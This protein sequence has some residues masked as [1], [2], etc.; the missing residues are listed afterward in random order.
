M[1]RFISFAR[2]LEFELVSLAKRVVSRLVEVQGLVSGAPYSCGIRGFR[3]RPAPTNGQRV[4][5]LAL[6]SFGS[7]WT[8]WNEVL[9]LYGHKNVAVRV[10]RNF[11]LVPPR[12]IAYR[13]FR[14]PVVAMWRRRDLMMCLRGAFWGTL[15]SNHLD[16]E[17]RVHFKP[18]SL[19]TPG[20]AAHVEGPL[21]QHKVIHWL[22]AIYNRQACSWICRSRA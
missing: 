16:Y 10:L 17:T 5:V 6:E 8:L 7:Q 12:P 20:L 18:L 22:P 11:L 1:A 9:L 14:L 13:I 4:H 15:D 21:R 19:L 2:S 3:C